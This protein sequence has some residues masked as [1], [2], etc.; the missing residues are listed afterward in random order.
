MLQ[1]DVDGV[2]MSPRERRG[3]GLSMEK[4]DNGHDESWTLD[5]LALVVSCEKPIGH[6]KQS[7]TRERE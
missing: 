3:N 1:D 6:R 7:E 2:D 5:L 4:E